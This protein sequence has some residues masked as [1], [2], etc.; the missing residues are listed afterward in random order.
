MITYFGGLKIVC[1][2]IQWLQSPFLLCFFQ[3]IK[4]SYTPSSLS[5]KPV[6][7][8]LLNTSQ[9]T[10]FNS[11]KLNIFSKSMLNVT[12]ISLCI[13]RYI[14]H[15]IYIYDFKSLIITAYN[16]KLCQSSEDSLKEEFPNVLN[17]IASLKLSLHPGVMTLKES[18]SRIWICVIHSLGVGPN[19]CYLSD[20]RRKRVLKS[21]GSDWE[22][23]PWP[24]R[25]SATKILRQESSCTRN[26]N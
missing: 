11:L 17:I 12:D 4:I 20:S 23:W 26:L 10:F 2:T 9:N 24:W 14:C 8:I 18:T 25:M 21:K 13:N 16:K 6:F 22:L 19:R 15:Y 1:I 5:S 7:F 3:K